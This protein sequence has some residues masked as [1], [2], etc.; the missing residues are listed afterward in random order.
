M[1]YL[2]VDETNKVQ[3]NKRATSGSSYWLAN[4]EQRGTSPYA[5]SGYKVWRNV[6]DY[7]AK[8]DGVTDDTAAINKVISDGGRC[9]VN[10][11]SSTIYPTV[12][13]F[14]PGNYLVSSPL[15][16]Y[17][18][19]QFLGDPLDYLTILAAASFVGLRVIISDVYVGDSE[20]WY[21]NT[22]NFLCSVR[23]FKMDIT[24]TDPN[25][26]VCAIHWQVA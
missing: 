5:L 17:Y 4:L 1:E 25:A 6:K 21:L 15:I 18:N 3:L 14:P 23:N 12:V 19:T 24:R 13:F 26:Y 16:Q 8:G 22:N 11:G 2:A 7:G 20:E 10:C 9:G